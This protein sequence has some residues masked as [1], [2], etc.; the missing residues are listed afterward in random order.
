MKKHIQYAFL[1]IFSFSAVAPSCVL[2][3]DNRKGK[4]IKK[5]SEVVVVLTGSALIGFACGK[6]A[7]HVD[8]KQRSCNLLVWIV[9]A[10]GRRLLTHAVVDSFSSS[11]DAAEVRMAKEL[12]SD[13]AWAVD[14]I[15]YLGLWGAAV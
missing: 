1:G 5:I 8:F 3:D 4:A 15:T 13:V 14:W 11:Q 2:A 12:A 6:T 7:F 9:L 10:M